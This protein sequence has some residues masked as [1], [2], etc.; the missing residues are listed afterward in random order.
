[1]ERSQTDSC[2][3]LLAISSR[4]SSVPYSRRWTWISSQ[5][6]LPP[7]FWAIAQASRFPVSC[8]WNDQNPESASAYWSCISINL[9][10]TNITIYRCKRP[11]FIFPVVSDLWSGHRRCLSFFG[12]LYSAISDLGRL[13]STRT[14]RTTLSF[15]AFSMQLNTRPTH[16]SKEWSEC[17]FSFC[18]QWVLSPTLERAWIRNSKLKILYH[19]TFIF[20][21][22]EA[23]TQITWL[24]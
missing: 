17:A 19:K 16:P 5:E 1:M 12:K 23:L 9:F 15:S 4:S 20:Q 7:L 18:R 13:W 22:S 8:W 2:Y 6:L 14:A 21:T 11:T 3:L 10:L 24:W